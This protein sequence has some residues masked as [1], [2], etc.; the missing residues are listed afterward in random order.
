MRR[1]SSPAMKTP[2]AKKSYR[3][4]PRYKE[5]N[6]AIEGLLNASKVHVHMAAFNQSF[7]RFLLMWSDAEAYLRQALIAYAGVTQDVGRALFSGTRAQTA[8]DYVLAI[9]HNTE[10]AEDRRKSLEGIFSHM[11]AI[12]T[13]RD[14]LTHHGS[15]LTLE[16]T[17][18]LDTRRISD[19]ERSSR[20]GK[21]FS[22]EVNPSVLDDMTWDLQRICAQLAHHAKFSV[23]KFTTPVEGTAQKGPWRFKPPQPLTTAGKS[24]GTGT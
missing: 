13:L 3:D 9:A 1:P 17:D 23:G 22:F 6:D 12:N 8:M 19:G 7:G 14:R 4:D 16:L 18:G 11:K 5:V 20:K 2:K 21:G 24:K 15:A 10:M